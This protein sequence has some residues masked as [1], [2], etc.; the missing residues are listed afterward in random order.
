MVPAHKEAGENDKDEETWTDTRHTNAKESALIFKDGRW[1]TVETGGGRVVP[2]DTSNAAAVAAQSE[3]GFH[4]D[5]VAS[6]YT[7]H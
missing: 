3:V 6:K 5:G 4:A 1:V 7:L 2:V